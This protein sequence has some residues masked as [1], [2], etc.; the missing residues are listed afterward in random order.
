MAP[1]GL[2]LYNFPP[3]RPPP[4]LPVAVD[5]LPNI[6]CWTPRAWVTGFQAVPLVTAQP[7][8]QA[9]LDYD[10]DQKQTFIMLDLALLV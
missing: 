10:K 6:Y 9:P 1:P 5:Q 8:H 2:A 4:T 3:S 7:P